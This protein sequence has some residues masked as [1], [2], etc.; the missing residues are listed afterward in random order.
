MVDPSVSSMNEKPPFESRRVLTHPAT[1]TVVAEVLSLEDV[2][3][4]FALHLVLLD[5]SRR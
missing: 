2:L 3:D 5:E 4:E 1:V